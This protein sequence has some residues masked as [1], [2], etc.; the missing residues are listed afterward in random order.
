[1][2][3]LHL[4]A[5]ISPPSPAQFSHSVVS[6]SLRPHE[7][8]PARPPCP[9]PTPGDHSDSCPSS[10][11][12]HPA[13]SSSVVPFSSCPQSL[14]ASG[15]F[16]RSQLF[17]LGG[18]SSG[19]SAS[20]SVLLQTPPSSFHPHTRVE[21]CKLNHPLS[22]QHLGREDQSLVSPPEQLEFSPA[23]RTHRADNSVLLLGGP[24]PVSCLPDYIR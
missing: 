17:I 9:S 13:I 3:A 5:P 21:T 4:H 2:V 1:M 12:C 19:V 23:K 20:A 11:W 7:P 8:R 6:D 15:S 24:A 10:Q 18:Q 22:G 14:P 16:Q